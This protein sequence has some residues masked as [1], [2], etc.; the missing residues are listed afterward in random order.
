MNLMF[1]LSMYHLP[2][3]AL[4][5]SCVIFLVCLGLNCSFVGRIRRGGKT[6]ADSHDTSRGAADLL[7]ILHSSAVWVKWFLALV[8]VMLALAWFF[9]PMALQ[10]QVTETF[11][12]LA[13]LLFLAGAVCHLTGSILM[14]QAKGDPIFSKLTAE[15]R[16]V[17][18]RLVLV[19]LL[20][21]LI[22]LYLSY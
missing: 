11:R 5:A 16:P 20:C 19:G 6:T 7:S 2:I 12:V 15:A 1:G 8:P 9:S 13:V 18:V 3:L 17:P 10:Q 22:F 14:A 21:L 4:L